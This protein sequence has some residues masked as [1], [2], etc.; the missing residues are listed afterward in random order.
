MSNVAVNPQPG[1]GK[2]RAWS[3]G[4]EFLDLSNERVDVWRID[5]DEPSSSAFAVGILSPD[6]LA[7]AGRFHFEKDRLHFARCRSALR[8]LLSR[9]LCLSAA[10]LRFEYQ[11]N[12]KP[13]LAPRQNQRRLRFNVSHSASLALIAVSAVHNLG[14]DIEQ[15]CCDV[16]VAA[17]AKGFF[18]TREQA[19]LRDLPDRLRVEAFFAC[20][21]RK[22]SF[23]KAT[24]D[25]L[26]F[27]LADFSVTAHPELDPT[28]EE[29]RGSNE[30]AKQWRLED[31]T[32]A[33]GYRATVAVDGSFSSL[34]TYTL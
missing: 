28:L 12:G 1:L 22:E 10:G 20:W 31:L 34:K 5:L 24:G 17:L 2:A 6:E 21:T 7:R 33:D 15:I 29:I 9:Y 8:S 4:P 16:D 19:V 13:E 25:G 18:S 3:K 11:P 30:D 26:S 14:I 23:L 32:V 27:P